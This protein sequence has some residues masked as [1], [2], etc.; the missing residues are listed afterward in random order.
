MKWLFRASAVVGSLFSYLFSPRPTGAAGEVATGV[1][2]IY[3]VSIVICLVGGGL[4]ETYGGVTRVFLVWAFHV[5]QVISFF[6]MAGLWGE[7]VELVLEG[8]DNGVWRGC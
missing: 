8:R 6:K 4:F 3:F 7:C 5:D 1:I 2:F